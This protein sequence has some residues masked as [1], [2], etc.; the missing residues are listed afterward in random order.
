MKIS[1]GMVVSMAINQAIAN[2]GGSGE[3]VT[4]A[5]TVPLAN[6]PTASLAT[7]PSFGCVSV[8]VVMVGVMNSPVA[9][10]S[11]LRVGRGVVRLY[12]V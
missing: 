1:A 9:V 12:A 8:G 11:N 6:S 4:E 7:I 10:S 2:R 3:S 5:A